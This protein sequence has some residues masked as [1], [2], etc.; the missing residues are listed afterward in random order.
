MNFTTM[1]TT[2]Q[3]GNILASVR[4]MSSGSM[5]D[6]TPKMVMVSKPMYPQGYLSRC[7]K[8]PD[9]NVVLKNIAKR[10]MLLR[11]DKPIENPSIDEKIVVRK[12]EELRKGRETQERVHKFPLFEG[13]KDLDIPVQASAMITPQKDV[14]SGM[15]KRSFN[16]SDFFSPRSTDITPTKLF[17]VEEAVGYEYNKITK[18]KIMEILKSRDIPFS[19]KWK[20]K[21]LFDL[22]S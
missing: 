13:H 2:F 8:L 5:I 14:L 11:E 15:T 9:A 19:D 18:K 22:L 16:S 17:P 10:P 12:F 1:P 7:E 21:K 6:F 4:P 3:N 20:K